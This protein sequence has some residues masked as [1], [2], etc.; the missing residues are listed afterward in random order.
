MATGAIVYDVLARSDPRTLSAILAFVK[1]L[2]QRDRMNAALQ[3]LSGSAYD[4]VV[5]EYLARWPDDVR[6]GPFD[7]PDWHYA[8]Q[9]ISLQWAP[10]HFTVGQARQAYDASMAVLENPRSSPRDRAIAA[11]WVVHLV[12][13][14][15]QPLH[16]ATRLVLPRFA[17]TDRTGT[18]GF[19]R[20][21]PGGAPRTLHDAWDSAADLPGAEASAVEAL[22]GRLEAREL[23]LPAAL[24]RWSG[25]TDTQ[26]RQWWR[27]SYALALSSAYAG[28]GRKEAAKP[29]DAPLLSQAYQDNA[30]RIAERRIRL[31]GWRAAESLMMALVMARPPDLIAAE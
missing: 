28:D 21:T 8:V 14:I 26:F 7:H 3:G 20:L 24:T 10:V 13:D 18:S 4:R 30:R 12:G 29:D 9:V 19:V 15:H 31:S 17:M 27:E 23:I 22:V 6:G 2:P 11:A 5:F 16:T 25:D 1:F